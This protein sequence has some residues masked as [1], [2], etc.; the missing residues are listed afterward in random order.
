MFPPDPHKPLALSLELAEAASRGQS[1]GPLSECA[2]LVRETCETLRATVE[3]F[4]QH[5]CLSLELLD[6]NLCAQHGNRWWEHLA[7]PG[8]SSGNAGGRD[9]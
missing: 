6:A 8:E 2:V 3:A 9:A 1:Q 4:E 5:V 7:E